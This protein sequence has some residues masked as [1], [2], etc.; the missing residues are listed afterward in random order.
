MPQKVKNVNKKSLPRLKEATS[1]DS[2]VEVEE[3]EA[4]A[5]EADD[6]FSLYVRGAA[7]IK[8]RDSAPNRLKEI[9]PK[10]QDVR[11][12]RQKSADY[13][14]I[15]FASATDRDESYEKLKNHSELM[16]RQSTKNVPKKL[17]KRKKIVAEKREA[18][19]ETR[20]L[21]A[22]IKKNEKLNEST[23][24]KTNQII[25]VNLPLQVT[26]TEL[27]QQ[28]PKAVK[29][30]VKKNPKTKTMQ[31]AI[32]SFPETYEAFVASKESILLHGQK[33]NVML[34]KDSSL[35]Q[36]TNKKSKNKGKGKRKSTDAEVEN[37][38]PEEKTPKVKGN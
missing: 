36:Q 19:K 28:Y 7:W 18:K 17:E 1:I 5:K 15:D 22:K 33:I 34:N 31:T 9:E 4:V 6:K 26:V 30:V 37:G 25:I 2:D 38:E 27:K 12:P 23:K 8:D 13:C 10:I 21:I 14:F 32:I 29:V 20:K 3:N 16:V 24:E 11:H 35:K